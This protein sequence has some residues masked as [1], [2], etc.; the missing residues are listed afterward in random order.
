MMKK[1]KYKE[2]ICI[3]VCHTKKRLHDP[4][5]QH[6]PQPTMTYI[7]RGIQDAYKFSTSLSYEKQLSKHKNNPS[8]GELL[9]I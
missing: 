2:A 7:V 3:L 9:K 5:V 6:I 8:C 4:N 1:R